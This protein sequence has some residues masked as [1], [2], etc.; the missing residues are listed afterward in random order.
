L[1]EFEKLAMSNMNWILLYPRWY[2]FHQWAV[3]LCRLLFHFFFKDGIK[4]LLLV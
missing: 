4:T 1:S 3:V 2:F